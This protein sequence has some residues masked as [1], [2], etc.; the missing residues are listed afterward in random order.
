MPDWPIHQPER[1]LRHERST[2]SIQKATLLN[3]RRRDRTRPRPIS[4]MSVRRKTQLWAVACMQSLVFW[5][6]GRHVNPH[7]VLAPL[8]AARQ[9]CR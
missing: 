4:G 8:T 6:P 1:P 5:A 7:A 2:D 3:A 9:D